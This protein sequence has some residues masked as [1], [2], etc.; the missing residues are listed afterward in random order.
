MADIIVDALE[1]DIEAEIQS[2]G[3]T[4]ITQDE[5]A[6]N[7]DT[8]IITS[9][10]INATRPLAVA[11]NG[12][13]PFD[14]S[15]KTVKGK[16]VND[17]AFDMVF[18]IIPPGYYT[19]GQEVYLKTKGIIEDTNLIGAVLNQ[20]VYV[21]ASGQLSLT[22]SNIK[23]GEVISLAPIRIFLNIGKESSDND[24]SN[25]QLDFINDSPGLNRALYKLSFDFDFIVQEF[26]ATGIY[27]NDINSASFNGTRIVGFNNAFP[28]KCYYSD[29]EGETWSDNSANYPAEVIEDVAYG[30]GVFVAIGN[31]NAYTSADGITWTQHALPVGAAGNDWKKIHFANGLF[32]AGATTGAE[33]VIKSSDG[34]NWAL[35]GV[36]ASV[37]TTTGITYVNANWIISSSDS[38]MMVY[39]TDDFATHT[40]TTPILGGV[41]QS[42]SSTNNLALFIGTG[43][44]TNSIGTTGGGSWGAVPSIPNLSYRNVCGG[45][46]LFLA[47]SNV[48]N[49]IVIIDVTTPGPSYTFW[50]FDLTKPWMAIRLTNSF[51]IFSKGILTGEKI[52]KVII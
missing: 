21:N 8:K 51:L 5:L 41:W 12:A 37:L 40:V 14:S 23:V 36:S 3:K 29:N 50:Q 27:P 33:R 35:C 34:I 9:A 4:L 11:L 6:L 1:V 15:K 48:S 44:T 22:H 30:A 7:E 10:I 43:A 20:P 32:V 42:I 38:S 24:L 39:S 17:L 2:F 28:Y 52:Y 19:A 25:I 45:N 47:I 31:N 49:K 13:S 26:L 46:G 16:V 18:G